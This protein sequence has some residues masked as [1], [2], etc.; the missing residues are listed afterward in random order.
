[1]YPEVP[2]RFFDKLKYEIRNKVLI[3]VSILKLRHKKRKKSI[4]AP[5]V[6]FNFHFK[7]GMENE[8]FVYLNFDSKLKIER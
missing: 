2:F 1:M 5:K 6:P 3:F 7:I 8:I 4:R